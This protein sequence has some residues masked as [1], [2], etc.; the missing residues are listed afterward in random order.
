MLFDVAETPP[1][2]TYKL[3]VATVT[4]RPIAWI[5]SQ[6]QDGRRN[7]APFSF[8][9]VFAGSPPIFGVG[10]GRMQSG[11]RKH[12]LRNILATRHFTVNLVPDRLAEQMNIT[13][14]EF[15]DGEDELEAAGL[16]T[17]PSQKI[18]VPRIADSPVSFEAEL[19]QTVE[20]GDF[21]TLVLGRVLAIHIADEA[22]LDP[23]R[24]YVDTPKLDL[25]GRMHG[26]GW[27]ARSRDRF[28][29]P[30]IPIAEWRAKGKAASK[31][32]Q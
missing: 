12:T 31:R 2:E 7:A 20:L 32:E 22:L 15:P 17:A 6:D 16:P 27:Y 5:V 9:N 28:S 3:L 19:Y 24:Y 1:H 25:I 18:D 29:L 8:F 30:R 11:E 4:P 26:A 14:T 21:N 13:A 23:A 10:I